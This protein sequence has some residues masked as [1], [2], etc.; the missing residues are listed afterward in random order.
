MK[1]SAIKIIWVIGVV[2]LVS[3]AGVSAQEV[4][5]EDR[6]NELFAELKRETD[7]QKATEIADTIW[8]LW[9][10]SKSGS[11]DLLTGWARQAIQKQQYGVALDLLDQVVVMAPDY[12]EGWNQR[13]IL[14][15]LT[16]NYAR[17]IADIERTLTLE[18]RHFGALAGLANI[19]QALDKEQDALKTWYEVLRIYPAMQSAQDAVVYLEENLE[20]DAL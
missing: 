9:Y 8:G 19:Q 14:H 18:P 10:T 2:M 12:S 5:K 6:L 17:S 7:T 1:S 15:Y 20:G 13:A 4:S 16:N 3:V 11:V